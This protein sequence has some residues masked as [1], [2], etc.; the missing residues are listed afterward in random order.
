MLDRVP[1]AHRFRLPHGAFSKGLIEWAQRVAQ[2]SAWGS[3]LGRWGPSCSCGLECRNSHWTGDLQVAPR[4]VNSGSVAFNGALSSGGL[5]AVLLM[6]GAWLVSCA[7]LVPPQR[8]GL[9][10]GSAA[11][12]GFLG[13]TSPSCCT[14]PSGARMVPAHLQAVVTVQYHIFT[15]EQKEYHGGR[16]RGLRSHDINYSQMRA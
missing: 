3:V 5:G 9:V 14:C 2:F 7:C 12:L 10:G 16:T 8:V 4:R 6:F 11:G 1:G 15:S 13:R